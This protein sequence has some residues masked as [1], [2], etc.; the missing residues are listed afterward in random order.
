MQMWGIVDGIAAYPS[1]QQLHS[2]RGRMYLLPACTCSQ[3]AQEMAP[4]LKYS[5][6]QLDSLPLGVPAGVYRYKQG[7][8]GR[9]QQ[10]QR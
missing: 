3:V 8:P 7:Y 9:L 2:S 10:V 6:Q 4:A 1:M 5:H